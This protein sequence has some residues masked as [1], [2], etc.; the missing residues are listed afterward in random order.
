MTWPTSSAVTRGVSE[1]LAGKPLP[2]VRLC[3]CE[4]R[5][6]NLSA[7]TCG[8]PLVIYLYPGCSWSPDDGESTA[9]VDAVQHRAFRDHKPDLDARGYRAIGI[10]SQSTRAQTQAIIENRIAHQL[11]S[12]PQ[13][14][15]AQ[16]LQLPTFLF[17]GSSWYRRLTLVI[18]ENR[19]AKAFFPVSSAE[20]SAAQ[21]IAWMMIQG[22]S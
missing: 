6:F 12:E 4:D 21:V 19:I 16:R 14:Q 3:S 13:L 9:R 20:R 2:A 15:L 18:T 7:L 17:E 11:F 8:F 10:S 22:I 1:R 5:P